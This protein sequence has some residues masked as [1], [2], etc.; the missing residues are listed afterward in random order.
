MQCNIY[1]D[2]S[3][4]QLVFLNNLLLRIVV[5]YDVL[6]IIMRSIMAKCD[7][8]QIKCGSFELKSTI[9]DQPMPA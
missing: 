4:L 1:K 6:I 5:K 7:I 2:W 3:F 8:C 9:I